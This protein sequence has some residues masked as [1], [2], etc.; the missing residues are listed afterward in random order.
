[1]GE[2]FLAREEVGALRAGW[3]SREALVLVDDAARDGKLALLASMLYVS[4]PDGWTFGFGVAYAA[5]AR[6][7]EDSQLRAEARADAPPS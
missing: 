7:E 1:M 3:T 6:D 5:A 4:R 2:R